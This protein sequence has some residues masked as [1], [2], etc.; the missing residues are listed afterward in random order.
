MALTVENICGLLIRSRL[1]SQE[2]VKALYTRWKKEAKKEAGETGAFTQW[3]VA[4]ELVT[5]FQASLLARGLADNFFLNDYK[6]MDRMSQGRL[7]GVYKAVHNSGQVVALKVLPPSRAKDPE[8][9][10]RF[11]NEARQSMRLKHPNIVRTFQMGEANGA[12]YLVLE[13]LEGETLEDVLKRRG[14]LPAAEG[15][16]LVYQALLGLQHMDEQGEMHRDLKPANL[17]L[18]PGRKEGDT[19][20]DATIKIVDP[21]LARVLIEDAVRETGNSAGLE[22]CPTSPVPGNPDYL[23]PES[24]RHP[25]QSDIRADIYSLGCV[26]YHVLAGHPPFPDSN[27]ISQMIRHATEAPRPLAEFSPEIPNALEQI[28]AWM[29]AKD[30]AKRYRTP[31]RAAQALEVFL[32]AG[33]AGVTAAEPEA[34]LRSEPVT[35]WDVELVPAQTEVAALQQVVLSFKGLVLTRRDLLMLGIGG[36]AIAVAGGIGMTVAKLAGGKGTPKNN[37]SGEGEDKP[38]E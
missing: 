36:A 29:M 15:V 27:P 14:H 7:A 22:T 4:S 37:H 31:E 3:L 24:A 30:P 8:F 32:A 19:T 34:P 33:S 25:N 12:R 10:A 28:L 16:R 35:T 9:A 20:L 11:Q 13:Y 1:L 18:A 26:L 38:K 5:Q 2:A 17:L 6:L 21:H 23:A